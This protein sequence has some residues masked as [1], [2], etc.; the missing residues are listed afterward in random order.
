MIY[1]FV[2]NNPFLAVKIGAV[3]F[4]DFVKNHYEYLVAN[5]TNGHLDNLIALLEPAITAFEKWETS[6]DESQNTRSG[7]TNSLDEIVKGFETFMDSVWKEVSYKFEDDNH[8][9]F[10]QFFP[11]GKSEFNNI[12]RT[13]APVL[14]KRIA[15]LCE[16]HR[17][18]IKA[19]MPEQAT[20]FY[21]NYTNKR[22]EQ[23]KEIGNVQDGSDE[24]ITLRTNL[25][26][27]MK[28]VLL[29]LLII[30]EDNEKEVFK[31][32]DAEVLNMYKRNNGKDIPP[33]TP[34]TK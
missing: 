17:T 7:K 24:G 33:P 29:R 3:R 2:E 23:Q 1:Q 21:D 30:H 27:K 15:N 4:I 18:E 11:S 32:Y 31:Y 6:Q 14:L 28:G 26:K 10:V 20:A 34:P 12:T 8:E 22:K 25:A 9:V 5:N 16:T 19:G 13:D